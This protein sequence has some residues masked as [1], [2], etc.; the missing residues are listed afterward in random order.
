MSLDHFPM[1]AERRF[2]PSE[3]SPYPSHDNLMHTAPSWNYSARSHTNTHHS[4]PQ[5][6]SP[7]WNANQYT[8]WS[9]PSATIP[10]SSP[11]SPPPYAPVNSNYRHAG[12]SSYHHS[13]YLVS[14]P[15]AIISAN[16]SSLSSCLS[17]TASGPRPLAQNNL[18]SALKYDN[19]T[20]GDGLYTID[21]PETASNSEP[22]AS[23]SGATSPSARASSVSSSASVAPVKLEPEDSAGDC[24][25]ME[26][27]ACTSAAQASSSLAPPT[28]VPLRATQASKAMRKMMGVFRLNPFS[29]HESS[30]QATTTWTGEDA[31][32]LEEEPQ[33]FEFQLDVPGCE[34]AASESVQTQPT[35]SSRGN[36]DFDDNS[37]WAEGN[38][39]H[40][41][42]STAS[43]PSW[44]GN[45][46][47]PS[48]T[49]PAL[50]PYSP[51]APHS[52]SS[53]SVSSRRTPLDAATSDYSSAYTLPAPSSCATDNLPSISTMARRW[54][55]TTNLQ[56]PFVL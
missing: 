37:S 21:D 36:N 33:M 19:P 43:H 38:E 8:A 52:P 51:H 2:Q 10:S 16:Q 25:V 34:R 27:S 47:S 6:S 42:Y 48:Y 39:P 5:H 18:P 46:S 28:E 23:T 4:F 50:R 20:W 53:S 40:S 49:L 11:S 29:M 9:T 35:T 56:A 24:F 17:S 32:P 12:P 13:N 7:S 45:E 44:L 3:T 54:S 55:N 31:G 22:P 41:H 15:R 30:G 26:F 14:S 1:F